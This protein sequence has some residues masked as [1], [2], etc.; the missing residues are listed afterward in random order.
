MG[1]ILISRRE[2]IFA[3]AKELFQN[4]GVIPGA[5][6]AKPGGNIESAL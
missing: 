2:N 3:D 4:S 6:S 5:R 1:A